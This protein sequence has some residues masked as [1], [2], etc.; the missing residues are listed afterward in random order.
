LKEKKIVENIR[1]IHL[2][3]QETLKKSREKYKAQHGQ[4]RIEK[5]FK[6]GDKVWLY[7]NKERLQGP[8][9]KSKALQYGPFEVFEKVGDMR[10]FTQ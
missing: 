2:Q 5:T 7:L 4:H 8:S 10:T 6:L 3:V 9:K 1:Q